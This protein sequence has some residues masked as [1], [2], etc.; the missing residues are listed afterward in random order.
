MTV[1]STLITKYCT[2]HASDSLITI[3]QGIGNHRVKE[4]RRSKI[5]PVK[6]WRGAMSYWG[7]AGYEAHK[8]STF[9][10]LIQ[11]TQTA[12]QY[13][14]A[15]EFANSVA[16]KLNGALSA[17]KMEKSRYAGIGIHFTVLDCCVL[18]AGHH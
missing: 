9:D 15:E 13:E 8:W 7:L 3:Y 1:I 18:G 12:S 11:Q 10:W 5:V 4:Y 17:M 2:V 16:R 14:T 6:H